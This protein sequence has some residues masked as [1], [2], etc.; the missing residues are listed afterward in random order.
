MFKTEEK[1]QIKAQSG[2]TGAERSGPDVSKFWGLTK[3]ESDVGDE[4]KCCKKC[5]EIIVLIPKTT[6][7]AAAPLYAAE[8]MEEHVYVC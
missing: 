4:V 5:Q 8:I 7:F 6:C 3:S 1:F 2:G